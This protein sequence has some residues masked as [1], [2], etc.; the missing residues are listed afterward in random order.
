MKALWHILKNS[1]FTVTVLGVVVGWVPL[2]WFERHARWPEQWTGLHFAALTLGTLALGF[3][4]GQWLSVP[5]IA[6]G[7]AMMLWAY[8][9]AGKAHPT[10]LD[11]MK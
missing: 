8:A 3:S 9:R 6:A 11:R 10:I 1:G 7:I 5:M 2:R 4:M